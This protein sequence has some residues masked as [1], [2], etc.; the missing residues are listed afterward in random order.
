[1]MHFPI[2]NS[3]GGFGSTA[4]HPASLLVE[5][6]ESKNRLPNFIRA[7]LV[8]TKTRM[9]EISRCCANRLL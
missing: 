2:L 3:P 4:G 9:T 5:L 8:Q 7:E 6:G 1:M